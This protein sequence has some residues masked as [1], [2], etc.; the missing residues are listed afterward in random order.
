MGAGI[1]GEAQIGPVEVGIDASMSDV[2]D[3]LEFGAM[4]AYRADNGT[5]SFTGDATFMD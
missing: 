1:D 3:A 5:W 4:L 2:L